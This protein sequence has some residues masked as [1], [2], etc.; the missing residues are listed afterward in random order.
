M[1]SC[2]S[3]LRCISTGSAFKLAQ[4]EPSLEALARWVRA[5]SS[6]NVVE[7]DTECQCVRASPPVRFCSKSGSD[8][9]ISLTDLANIIGF[10]YTAHVVFEC[11]SDIRSMHLW[12]P[13]STWQNSSSLETNFRDAVLQ[14]QPHSRLCVRFINDFMGYGLF[15]DIALPAGSLIC[16]YTGVVR[17]RPS[18][19]AYAVSPGFVHAQ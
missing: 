5:Y 16:E 9:S 14:C 7:C 15:T 18:C 1:Q 19:S 4:P 17:A 11:D 8:S 3:L 12:E 6:S 13:S 10:I 2:R